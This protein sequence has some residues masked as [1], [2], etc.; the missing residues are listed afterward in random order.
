MSFF[1][2]TAESL[3]HPETGCRDLSFHVIFGCKASLNCHDN[4]LNFF[5]FFFCSG[6]AFIHF[7]F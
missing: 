1:S 5:G 6:Q 3:Q 4:L 2:L 7:W